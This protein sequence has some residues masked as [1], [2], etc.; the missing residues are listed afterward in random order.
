MPEKEARISSGLF[1]VNPRYCE[2][3][4]GA[5]IYDAQNIMNFLQ[6][7]YNISSQNELYSEVLKQFFDSSTG[8]SAMLARGTN[9]TYCK[10]HFFSK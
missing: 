4:E 9:K 3:G 5:F 2:E 10:F 8:V 7:N 6:N 1:A